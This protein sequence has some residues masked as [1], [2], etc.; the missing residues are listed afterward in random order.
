MAR[1]ISGK[2]RETG[3]HD[4][5]AQPEVGEELLHLA[6]EGSRGPCPVLL[7]GW[8]RR[9]DDIVSVRARRQAAF[10]NKAR[11]PARATRS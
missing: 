11:N 5:Q 4:E 10:Y 2:V 6:G 8:Q 7:T 9:N 3:G 1:Q